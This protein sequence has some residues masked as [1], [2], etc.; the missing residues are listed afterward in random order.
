MQL[1]KRM[2]SHWFDSWNRLRSVNQT[3]DQRV[4]KQICAM[5]IHMQRLL[6]VAGVMNEWKKSRS[7]WSNLIFIESF[8]GR[9]TVRSENMIKS[10]LLA[11]PLAQCNS[12]INELN[13]DKPLAP[14]RH[15]IRKSQFCAYDSTNLGQSCRTLSGGALQIFPASNSLLPKIVGVTS[16]GFGGGCSS[17]QP[18]IFTRVAHFVPWIESIVWPFDRSK[19]ESIF[20]FRKLATSLVYVWKEANVSKN[21]IQNEHFERSDSILNSNLKFLY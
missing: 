20:V 12:T 3:C 16:F 17:K 4:W 5:K 21:Q 14:L 18:G 13:R 2:I 6:K 7:S 19:Y 11:M 9:H 10:N 8:S 1:W 15:G